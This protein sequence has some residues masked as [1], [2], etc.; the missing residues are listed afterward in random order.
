MSG[1]PVSARVARSTSARLPV[2]AMF[3]LCCAC[4]D[5]D[6]GDRDKTTSE[7]A[8]SRAQDGGEAGAEPSGRNTRDRDAN[9][10]K[11]DAKVDATPVGTLPPDAETPALTPGDESG[12]EPDP[13]PTTPVVPAW[14]ASL[15]GTYALRT[16]TFRQD[17]FGTITRGEQIML[18]SFALVEGGLVLR[19]KLCSYAASTSIAEMKMVDATGVPERLE[20]VKFADTERR[21]TT[22]GMPVDIAFTRELPAICKGKEGASVTKPPAHVWTTKTTC[23]CPEITEAPLAD[24]CRVLDPDGDQAPGLTFTLKGTAVFGESLLYGAIESDSRLSNGQL[25]EDG[26][27]SAN[28]RAAETNYQLGCKPADCVDIAMLGKWCPSS[29]NH[30]EFVPL[31][32]EAAPASGYSCATVLAN[33]PTLFPTP[34]LEFPTACF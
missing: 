1:R 33:L 10:P 3:A 34:P 18:S 8:A 11:L 31:A 25:L 6:F 22:E 20:N 27:L 19:S 24:D 21:W 28:V 32:A 12:I 4:T 9:A 7:A 23:R 5:P 29:R 16:Y 14:A 30:A 2:A 15:P 17:D 26:S 13:T